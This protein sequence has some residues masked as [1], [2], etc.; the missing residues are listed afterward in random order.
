[1]THNSLFAL[2]PRTSPVEPAPPPHNFPQRTRHSRHS[3]AHPPA[4]S[5]APTSSD[6]GA[7]TP[8]RRR[9][10]PHGRDIRTTQLSRPVQNYLPTTSRIATRKLSPTFQYADMAQ[11]VQLDLQRPS[12][13]LTPRAPLRPHIARNTPACDPHFIPR[14]APSSTSRPYPAR[15]PQSHRPTCL[16]PAQTCCGICQ[17]ASRS[18]A[19]RPRYGEEARRQERTA[20]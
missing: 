7:P 1:M 20:L 10:P 19:Q 12:S 15:D 6:P 17:R 3:K 18:A 8:H 2:S 11:A 4:N 9:A 16:W 14:R 5:P 13:T